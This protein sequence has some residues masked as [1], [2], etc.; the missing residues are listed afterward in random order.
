MPLK[1]FLFTSESVSEGHPD[2]LCD[3]ISD[4]ILD[5]L[6]E[7]W[8]KMLQDPDHTI[9]RQLFV[10]SGGKGT[11]SPAGIISLDKEEPDLQHNQI[12]DLKNIEQFNAPKQKELLDAYLLRSG[13]RHSAA[14]CS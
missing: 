2:K 3:Q 12:P 5:A 6:I 4:S 1:D 11:D 10:I 14:S 9:Y 8:Y 13:G 7:N